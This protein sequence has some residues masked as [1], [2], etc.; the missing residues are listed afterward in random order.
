MQ[1]ILAHQEALLAGA[2]FVCSELIAGSKLE[3]NAIYQVV[4]K[5]LKKLAGK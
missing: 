2:L 5:A 3:S 1:W 4:F